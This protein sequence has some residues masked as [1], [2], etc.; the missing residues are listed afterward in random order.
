MWDPKVV[1]RLD[2]VARESILPF[3]DDGRVI[4][5]YTDNEIG[6]WNAILYKNTLEQAPS[7]GQRQR[8]IQLLRKT[9][10]NDWSALLLDF[11]TAPMLESWADLEKHGMLYLR[12][13]GNGIQV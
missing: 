2:Q 12:P 13:G 3:R 5:Y 1:A 8:L 10:Q 7:S 4:G 11:E 9:Y 6:W